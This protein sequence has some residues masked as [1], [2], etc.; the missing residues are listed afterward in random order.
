M[1]ESPSTNQSGKTVIRH[2]PR[3]DPNGVKTKQYFSM[4]IKAKRPPI[5]NP[6]S[7]TDTYQLPSFNEPK[8]SLLNQ[9]QGKSST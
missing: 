1:K 5:A 8:E 7:M 6:M 2:Y 3:S 4:T 9:P